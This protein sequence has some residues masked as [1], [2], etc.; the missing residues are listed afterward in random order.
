[1]I[2][3]EIK[4]VSNNSD[5]TTV[6]D[7]ETA[8]CFAGRVAEYQLCLWLALEHSFQSFQTVRLT[9][10]TVPSFCSYWHNNQI[11]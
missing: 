6:L 1:M 4:N 11:C 8:A 7:K 2:F 9:A 3:C 5:F 10:H